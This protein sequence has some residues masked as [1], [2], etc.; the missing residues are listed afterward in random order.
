MRPVRIPSTAH[1]RVPTADSGC[2][3]RD[4]D[5][6]L[7]ELRHREFVNAQH[8]RPAKPVNGRRAHQF[9]CLRSPAFFSL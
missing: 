9:R 2:V 8:L 3:E 6:S 5:F 4:E 7:V 1:V